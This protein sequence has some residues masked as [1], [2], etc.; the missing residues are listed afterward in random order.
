MSELNSLID[1]ARTSL[2]CLD[3]VLQKAKLLEGVNSGESDSKRE[4]IQ[5]HFET[6][7]KMVEMIPENLKR[8]ER[9][10]KKEEM[11]VLLHQIDQLRGK[12][13]VSL[14]RIESAVEENL[15]TLDDVIEKSDSKTPDEP[16][17][18]QSPHPSPSS[19][20][21]QLIG[22]S[23]QLLEVHD[24]DACI[25]LLQTVLSQD[26][27][28][29]EAAC[30]LSEAQRKWED[31]RLEE[32]LVVHIDN[33]KKEAMERFEK[34]HY[35]EC[36]G[37]FRFLCELEPQNRTLRDYLEL[38]QQKVQELND[39]KT[40][41]E[42]PT[43]DMPVGGEK[44]SVLPPGEQSPVREMKSESTPTWRQG[45]RL[46][47]QREMYS[48]AN[49][50]AQK[51]A[52]AARFF[53]SETVDSMLS[54]KRPLEEP[55][56]R[57]EDPLSG[58]TS[59]RL[60]MTAGLL[61]AV[62]VSIG[63]VLGLRSARHEKPAPMCS[64]EVQS[65]PAGA[66]VTVNGE[67][68]GISPLQLESLAVGNYEV[69][70]EKEGY[71]RNTRTVRLDNQTPV[72]MSVTLEPANAPPPQEINLQERASGFFEQGRWRE[73][74][75]DCD[76][77][78][79]KDSQNGFALNLKEKMRRVLLKQGNQFMQ[80]ERW[81][82]ARQA[83]DNVLVVVPRDPE[84]LAALKIVKSKA[85]KNIVKTES[86]EDILRTKVQ[87]VREQLTA[88]VNSGNYFPPRPGNA[89]DLISQLSQLSPEDPVGKEKSDQ[90]YRDL[91]AQMQRRLQARD[92]E[93]AKAI[94][95]QIQPYFSERN[96][97][98]SLR[99]TLKAEESKMLEVKSSSIQGRGLA[100][101]DLQQG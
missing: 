90:I 93:N 79:A 52:F 98:R 3:A 67:F 71:Q 87:A 28:N 81:E 66:T 39:G 46:D 36:V 12:L 72:Q 88:A 43:P 78:L 29:P 86:K 5:R 47:E 34:A 56:F 7:M 2:L 68:K 73:A 15:R 8:E 83:L 21:T 45:G 4:G 75:Q 92:F 35:E 40:E 31:Q 97:F 25:K 20:P 50:L 18:A 41:S 30:M 48:A 17:E 42:R 69:Q 80:K 49:P 19:A 37:M 44:V 22:E 76:T 1:Q 95:R 96:E 82:E 58:L 55:E 16:F 101:H 65:A 62:L 26:P 59:R 91:L 9:L 89:M 27:G 60:K 14:G 61:V 6:L 23:R 54:D 53:T 77:I 70:I 38:S 33:L 51:A 57:E 99:D 32:E 11:G 84:A 74:N 85:K 10:V 63:L 13:E 24:Y 94:A 64:L 100:L